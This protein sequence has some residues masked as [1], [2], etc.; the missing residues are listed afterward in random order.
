MKVDVGSAVPAAKPDMKPEPV[1]P[2]AVTF[3]LMAVAAA[4]TPQP[5]V[6]PPWAGNPALPRTEK[7]RVARLAN[8]P[9]PRRVSTIRQWAMGRNSVS[10]AVGRM[11]AGA[12]ALR[13]GV[14]RGGGRRRHAE[15][16]CRRRHGDHRRPAGPSVH[17]VLLRSEVDRNRR[18]RS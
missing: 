7:V 2:T 13:G 17:R 6:G 16:D 14:G 9:P 15:G 10:V 5:P 12:N 8:A 4:G 11:A 3:A 1:A 18:T